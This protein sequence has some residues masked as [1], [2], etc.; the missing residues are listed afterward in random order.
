PGG[1]AEGFPSRARSGSA[2]RSDWRCPA[3]AEALGTPTPGCI[4]ARYGQT[5]R[6]H[7]YIP[8]HFKPDD[9][10]VLGLLT[11][12]GAADLVTSTAEGLM[13]PL[14]SFLFGPLRGR[15]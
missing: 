13:A 1:R 11:Q 10:T 15:A 9:A 3:S 6:D 12:H 4:L 8:A 14:A 5:S 7:V 2:R